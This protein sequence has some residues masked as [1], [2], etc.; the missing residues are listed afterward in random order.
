MALGGH[1]EPLSLFPGPAQAVHTPKSLGLV[2]SRSLLAKGRME[3][4][5][6]NPAGW[7]L[8]ALDEEFQVG[9]V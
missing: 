4:K 9:T 6:S 7:E 8:F 1:R 5:L 3:R 2:T